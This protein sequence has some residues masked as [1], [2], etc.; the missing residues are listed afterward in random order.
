V[1]APRAA[2]VEVLIDHSHTTLWVSTGQG[3][4]LRLSA[5]RGP[6][7][8]CDACYRGLSRRWAERELRRVERE[9]R[10]LGLAPPGGGQPE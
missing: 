5:I 8:V 1:G 3:C 6:L 10:K 4:I 7:L 2:A 9:A